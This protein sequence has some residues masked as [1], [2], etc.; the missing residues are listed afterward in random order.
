MRRDMSLKVV[1]SI[2]VTALLLFLSRSF[3]FIHALAHIS[4]HYPS[5]TAPKSNA[6]KIRW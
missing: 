4:V 1:P 6:R 2:K 3:T 5:I